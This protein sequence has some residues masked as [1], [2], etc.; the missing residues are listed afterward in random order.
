[1]LESKILPATF[2]QRQVLEVARDLLG[3]KLVRL[4]DGQ[5]IGGMITEVEAYDGEQDKA[6]H[7]RSGKT[8]RNY[9]MYGPSGRA[10]VY[11]VYGMHWM[12]NCVCGNIGYPAAVL[13]RALY[14]IEGLETI[15]RTRKGIHPKDWCSGPARLTKALTIDQTFNNIDLTN[16]KSCL[17]IE[18]LQSIPE[19][20]IIRSPRIGIQYAGEPWASFPWR[21]LVTSPERY[22]QKGYL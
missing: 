21:F 13:F 18:E 17:F 19:E 16:H 20:G 12:L 4:F 8:S 22:L 5:R 2:Y 3:K 11:F 1:L 9:V 6:C 14:P 10:Y 15:T 7:A